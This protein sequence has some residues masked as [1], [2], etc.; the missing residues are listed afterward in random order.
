ML[1]YICIASLTALLFSCNTMREAGRNTQ[2]TALTVIPVEGRSIRAIE[3][4]NDSTIFFAANN[5]Q[6]GLST[7]SGKTWQ[8]DQISFEGKFPSFRA[9]AFHSSA[10]FMLSIENPALLY[11]LKGMTRELVYTERHPDVFYDAM[12]FFDEQHGIAL[13][14]PID[15]CFSI[16]RTSDGGASWRKLACENMPPAIKGEAAF[17]ASN[18][19]LAIQGEKVWFATGGAVSRVF[20][21]SDRGLHW[22][23]VETPVIS[24]GQMTGIYSMDFYNDKVGIVMGGDWN[25][26]SSNRANKAITLDGGK[27]WNLVADGEGAAYKSC[28]RFVPGGEGKK[29]IAVSTSGISF[30]S[31]QGKTWQRI[32]EQGFYTVRFA[33]K[34]LA[35]L[36]GE[37]KIGLLKL[38]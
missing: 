7:D 33:T 25:E 30:S 14:D 35:Y 15:G 17:A 5:G 21:S 36:A 38:P 31:D 12:Q 6:T 8:F 20:F 9:T 22:K 27:T 24:G 1:K 13:G 32:H 19:N 3:V 34:N 10:L 18:S 4:L 16:L 37:N 28:V 26:K 2:S 23:V 11:R 29:I